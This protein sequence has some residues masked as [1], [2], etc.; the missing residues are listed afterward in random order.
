MRHHERVEETAMKRRNINFKETA[1]SVTE[2]ALI[3][4]TLHGSSFESAAG[5]PIVS[6]VVEQKSCAEMAERAWA[7]ESSRKL[8]EGESEWRGKVSSQ[9]NQQRHIF[10]RERG[11]GEE[12]GGR[13]VGRAETQVSLT[14]PHF[15]HPLSLPPPAMAVVANPLKA[16]RA[17]LNLSRPAS[18]RK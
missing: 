1:S 16:R 2:R 6:L 9:S 12:E 13:K 10:E 5:A 18:V 7:R 3:S 15:F 14:H 17:P 8:R 11:R 4:T